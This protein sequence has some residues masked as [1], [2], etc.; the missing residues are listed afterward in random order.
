MQVMKELTN[1]FKALANE[2]RLRILKLLL[3]ERE[4]TVS[5]ISERI[6]LSYKST[7]KHLIQLE[8]AGFLKNRMVSLNVYYSIADLN[9]GARKELIKLIRK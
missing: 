3:A 4:L 5:E 2:R 6:N 7:S 8:R 9:N 1:I